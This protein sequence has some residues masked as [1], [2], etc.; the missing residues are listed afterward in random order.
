MKRNLRF[1]FALL[2]ARL[3]ALA[4]R[5]AGR[6]GTSMPGSWAIIL[7]PD[8]LGRMPKPKTIIGVTG[9]NGKTSTANL[10]TD[11]LEENGV[12]CFSNRFGSN[13]NTGIV[14]AL[15][16]NSRFWGQPKHD[17]AVLEIDE[18]SAP[19]IFPYLQPDMLVC[20]NLCRDA[21]DRNAHIDFL[22]G[23]LNG[24][25][26]D[27]VKLIVNGDDLIT[28]HLKPGNSRVTFGI[29]ELPADSEARPNLVRDIIVCP[30]CG[31]KLEYGF[32]RY[33]H[34]G[35]ARCPGCGWGSPEHIDYE[36][37]AVEGETMCVTVQTPA[38]E[39]VY[40]LPG[41][42][43]TD[44]Y[45]ILAA[46]ALLREFGLSCQ[47]VAGSMKAAE[48]VK[49]RYRTEKAGGWEIIMQLAKGQSP[50]ASSRVFD[51]IAGQGEDC[52]VIL[53][54]YDHHDQEHSTENI[55]WI[56]EADYEFLRADCVKQI[57]AGGNRCYDYALR[58]RIAGIP[59][60][61]IDCALKPENVVKLVH[62]N[63]VRR[64]YI[65]YAVYTQWKAEEIKDLLVRRILAAEKG[66][67]A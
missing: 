39:E 34:I 14:S 57:V 53:L 36:I 11:I 61:R 32:L 43:I 66:E 9:T 64:I 24:N 40:R 58:A 6:Q 1:Y 48:L 27:G 60:E 44:L 3:T 12:S 29:A 28:A 5:L 42:G 2:F 13:V 18:R 30:E 8:F 22:V 15:L 17:V 59:A 52:A 54:N 45:N 50:I 21:M 49:S 26:G 16:Q 41:R 55:A 19:R 67:T 38:G 23:L 25:I 35:R 47:E 31:E 63:V 4:V 62:L 37:T 10:I 7:C 33:N 56:Y 46:I 65:L 51:S 20:T